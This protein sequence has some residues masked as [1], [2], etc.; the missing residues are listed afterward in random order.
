[1]T[2]KLL[3]QWFSTFS[4]PRPIVATHDNPT[5]P[6]YN[7]NK[8]NAIKLCTLN[9]YSQVTT[10]LKMVY[11]QPLWGSQP[12]VEYHWFVTTYEIFIRCQL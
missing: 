7:S 3:K 8:A 12:Q 9:T 6:I 4:V 2:V 10:P 11:D 1:M 5:T